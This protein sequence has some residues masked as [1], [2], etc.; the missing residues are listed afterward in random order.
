[1]HS[2]RRVSLVPMIG[3]LFF[4]SRH[5]ELV[6]G[7]I[8]PRSQ[9]VIESRED[10][11]AQRAWDLT[12]YLCVFASSREILSIGSIKHWV[13]AFAGTTDGLGSIHD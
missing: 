5:P 13:P 6:S 8:S 11:K 2:L 9:A 4:F 12:L 1:M 3:D 10:A 7:S